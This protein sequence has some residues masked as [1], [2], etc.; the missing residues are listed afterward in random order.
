M[1]FYS[2]IMT[3]HLEAAD[4]GGETALVGLNTLQ[5]IPSQESQ[6]QHGPLGL[7]IGSAPRDKEQRRVR[8]PEERAGGGYR[9]LRPPDHVHASLGGLPGNSG[10]WKG[11]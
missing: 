8:T 7:G 11:L 6:V 1:K 10:T 2:E 4:S 9:T 3:L 5:S